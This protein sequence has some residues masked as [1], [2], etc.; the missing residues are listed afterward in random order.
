MGFAKPNH[1]LVLNNSKTYYD[2]RVSRNLSVP[3]KLNKVYPNRYFLYDLASNFHLSIYNLDPK[4]Q[5]PYV[6]VFHNIK[7]TDLLFQF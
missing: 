4:L 1:Q 3:R 5:K 7:Q 6:V 2:L